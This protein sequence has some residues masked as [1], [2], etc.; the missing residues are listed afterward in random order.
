MRWPE[1]FKYPQLPPLTDEEIAAFLNQAV[2]ARIGT[3][4]EDGTIHM[5]PILF[6]YEN[7]QILMPTQ[8]VSRKVKNI[9]HNHQVSVLID[10]TS[11]PF[12]GVLIY[13][14]AELDYDNVVEKRTAI[15]ERTR[16]HEEA[17]AYA[18]QLSAQWNC[19]IIRVTP[20]RIV[21]FDYTEEKVAALN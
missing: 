1:D 4:N 20:T 15:F 3:L 13:G 2:F 5:T 19:V 7:G 8:D 17:L 21:S 16:S 10:T 14:T 11:F 18:E 6:K 12:K 9:K